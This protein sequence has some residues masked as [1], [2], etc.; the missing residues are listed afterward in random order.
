MSDAQPQ[1][2]PS[3]FWYANTTELFERGAYYSMAS[4]VVI[5]LGQLGLGNYWPSI[6][7]NSVLWT[8]VYFL[9][10]LSGTIADQIGFRKALIGAFVLLFGGYLLMGYPVWFGGAVLNP[11]IEAEVTA[12]AGVVVPVVAGIVLI[13]IGGSIVKP[14]ILGTAQ[15]SAG[16]RAALA[17]SI[18]YMVVNIGSLFGRGVS[19]YVR[20]R[21]SLPYIFAVS[22]VCALCALGIVLFLYREPAAAADKPKKSIGRIL[23]DMVLVLRNGRFALF[24]VVISGFWFLY[25]Q[26]YNIIPKYLKQVV[27]PNPAVDIYTMANP[28]VIVCCQLLITKKFGKMKP[29]RSIVVGIVLV[30]LSMALN[31]VPIFMQGG[32]RTD[33]GALLPVGSLFAV[34]T[35]ATIA[36]GELFTSARTFEYIGA[37]APKGQE[38][39]F[40]GYANLPTAIGSFVGG[41][42]APVIFTDIMCNGATKLDNG[43]L[44]LQPHAAATGWMILMAIGL[45]SA[46]SMWFFN[47]WLERHETATAA[48]GAA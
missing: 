36:F 17:F 30:S 20:T 32:V 21:S 41:L 48:G 10:I 15:K 18:F 38:G 22:T 26:V 4:F 29:I 35:V 28:L 46:A 44:E 42:L 14:C 45:A 7:N 31:L 11:Q 12:G 19:Y 37:L 5:Y 34:L 3:V 47:R 40:L 39:L 9:P 1:K 24:L 6:L 33:V 43:L 27:E 2:F 25:T 13:G 23:T 16:G 8:L